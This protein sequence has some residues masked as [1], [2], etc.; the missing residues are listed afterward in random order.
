MVDMLIIQL[1]VS[2]ETST[3]IC[4][5]VCCD[6]DT[7]VYKQRLFT[8]TGQEDHLL[9]E[10]YGIKLHF[11]SHSSQVYIEGS[12]SVVSRDD[13]KYA[14]PVR[15]E[16]VSAVYGISSSK[17]LPVPVTVQVQHCIPLPN[18]DEATRLGMSFMMA[19]KKQGP[20]YVFRELDGGDFRCDSCY[21]EIQLTHFCDI[22]II[23]HFWWWLGYPI[24]FFASIFYTQND[25]AKFV[26]TQNLAAHISVSSGIVQ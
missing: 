10:E 19:K 8:Y 3:S 2:E 17:P 7:D 9:W 22:A 6:A 1:K 26:V 18:N 14:F 4:N 11:P 13:E 21:G 24:P 5:N 20:P 15:S 16:L 25:K 23:S 12:V